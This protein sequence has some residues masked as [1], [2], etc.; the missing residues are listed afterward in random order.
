MKAEDIKIG[1]QVDWKFGLCTREVERLTKTKFV[2]NDTSCG[3]TQAT[4]KGVDKMNE[5]LEGKKSLLDLE[6]E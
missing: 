1:S 4:I 3:W 6:W 2:I 5:I